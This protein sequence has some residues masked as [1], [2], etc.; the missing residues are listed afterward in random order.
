MITGHGFKD[1]KAL[2]DISPRTI[3][4]EAGVSVSNVLQML[5]T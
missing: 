5:E 1:V 3:R 2:G 4:V